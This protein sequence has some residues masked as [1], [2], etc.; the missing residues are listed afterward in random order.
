MKQRPEGPQFTLIE[1][2]VVIAIIAILAAMLLPALQQARGKALMST[3]QGNLKQF[4]LANVSYL[5]DFDDQMVYWNWSLHRSGVAGFG[6]A[7][8]WFRAF[9]DYVGQNTAI[10][11]C[12]A[13][14]RGQ[15]RQPK[16]PGG[17]TAS[18]PFA[19]HDVTVLRWCFFPRKAASRP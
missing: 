2:L 5:N 6:E 3:C 16:R 17:A 12:G 10:Y 1:L 18:D 8:P 19:V 4:G 15:C 14:P 13:D 9:Y 11:N 7:N